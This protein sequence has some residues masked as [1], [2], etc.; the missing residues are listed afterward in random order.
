RVLKYD[1]LRS[2]VL[3]RQGDAIR[4]NPALL[5][6]A[7]HYRFEPRPVAVA[8]GNEKGRVERAIRFARESFFAARRY[9]DLDDLNAQAAQWCAGV[10]ADRPCREDPAITVREAFERE[11]PSLL[12]LPENP[13]PCELQLPV[14]V[15]KTPYVR[16]DLND[17]SIPHTHVRRTLTVRA[18]QHQVRILDGADVVAEHAR[19]YDRGVQIEIAAHI[20]ALVE[21]KR[22]ARHH[23]GLDHLAHAAPAARTLMLR[24]AERGSNL[25]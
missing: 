16:F 19:S 5:A 8:R 3:E 21:R 10:A 14:T 18:D 17:Y 7:S 9:A 12:A 13:Y 6:F 4:F 22:E 1:N 20:D 24:A 15:G 23:R 25:G 11:K 2:A